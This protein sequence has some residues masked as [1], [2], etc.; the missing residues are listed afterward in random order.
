MVKSGGQSQAGQ[1]LL[2]AARGPELFRAPATAVR[3]VVLGV[4]AAWKPGQEALPGVWGM[5]G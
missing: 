1:G 4:K 5:S 3:S 2:L